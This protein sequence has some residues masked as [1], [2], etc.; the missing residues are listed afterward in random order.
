MKKLICLLLA[1]VLLLAA[2]CS[3]PVPQ[4]EPSAADTDRQSLSEM[5]TAPAVPEKPA[6]QQPAEPE[7]PEELRQK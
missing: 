6:P 2:G 3:K 4:E 5:V 7:V 1:M